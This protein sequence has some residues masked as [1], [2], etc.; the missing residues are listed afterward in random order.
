MELDE[1]DLKQGLKFLVG[2]WQ[3]DYIVN[4]FSN[5]L[6]HIP[7]TEF[8][9]SDGT[10][11]TA[12]QYEF[13]EDH[14][15]V[16][17]DASKGKEIKGTW[18]QTGWSEFKYTV[19]DFYDIPDDNFRKGVETLQMMEGTHIVFSIGFL[20]IAMKKIADGVVTEVKKPGIEDVEMSE[21]D[22]KCKAIVGTYAVAKM[23]SMIGESFDVFPVEDILADLEKKVASGETDEHDLQ[24]TKSILAARYEFTDDHKVIARM[25]VPE[26]VS[27]EQIQAAI[28]A[29]EIH[30][31]KDGY[32][33]GETKEWRAVDGKYYY[34]TG[35]TREVFGEP[36]S[37]WDELKEEDGL[38]V[39]GSGFFRLKRI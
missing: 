28:D 21:E 32:F 36:Q 13:F 34:D 19:A 17:R 1:Q 24:Q 15:M 23:M 8:K 35:E 22:L 2:T 37:S 3:V 33:I 39:Y 38:L 29:G 9:S 7:A 20:A 11:F 10:D 30:D 25:K 31:Y 12:I 27:E 5:D 6:A 16:L 14:T 4:A 26:G 18:E